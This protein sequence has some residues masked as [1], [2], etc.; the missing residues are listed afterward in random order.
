M[1]NIFEKSK[2]VRIRV[3][4]VTKINTKT[5]HVETSSGNIKYDYLVIA[6]GATTNYFGNAAL[7]QNVFSMK[8]TFKA[9]LIRNHLLQHFE[10]AVTANHSKTKILLSVVIEG[11]GPT[12]V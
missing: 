5:N 3:S 12:A 7:E 9:L 11:G 4:T 1:R 8:S 6:T 2:N 10:D